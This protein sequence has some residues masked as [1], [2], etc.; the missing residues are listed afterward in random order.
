M[1]DEEKTKKTE[2]TEAQ[3]EHKDH[4]APKDEEPK[5]EAAE[6]ESSDNEDSGTAEDK[7]KS[8]LKHKSGNLAG[9]FKRNKKVSIPASV[10]LLL[11]V[12]LAVP[13]TRYMTLGLFLKQDFSVVVLDSKT[14]KPVSSAQVSLRGTT[15]STD[16]EGKATVRV[17]VGQSKLTIS[18]TYYKTAERG[19]TVT[20]SKPD[21]LILR[22]E[23]TGLLVPISVTNS[24]TRQAVANAVLTAGQSQAKTDDKGQATLVVP[25]GTEE[26]KATLSGDG[27]NTTDIIVK[28]T[29]EEDDTNKF[30][31]TPSGKIYFLSNQSGK[32]DVIKS[33][34]D[35]KNRE[36]VLPGTGKEKKGETVLLA[37]RDWKYLALKSR[38]DGGD[39]DKLFL[40]STADGKTTVMDEGEA[41]FR[42]TGWEDHKFIY[43]VTRE[44][45]KEWEAKKE[46][47]KSYDA[48]GRKLT[49]L[50]ET[51][52]S[53]K[54]YDYM[55]E[56]FNYIFVIEG[57]IVYTKAWTGDP[58]SIL[59]VKGKAATLNTI[60]PAGGDKKIINSFAPEG[61]DSY[62]ALSANLRNATELYL[63]F[64]D[65][66]K[67]RFYEY[68]GGTLRRL[69]DSTSWDEFYESDGITYLESPSGGKAF[70]SQR[71]DGKLGLFVG[72]VTGQNGKQIARLSTEFQTYGWYTEDYLLLSKDGSELFVMPVS[73]VQKED[74]LL[75][76][77][78][79]YRS[80]YSYYG[81][82]G[83]YGGL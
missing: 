28:A 50:D 17:P 10:V 34:L 7:P 48:D 76:V 57:T 68:E 21:E 65:G 60:S 53:G 30:G 47:L 13:F 59:R 35:G 81:Y 25:I 74:E 6:A 40:I 52:A 46:A 14:G 64:H 1:D 38:R 73:G 49:T 78:D 20:L 51:A 80:E 26:L 27:Y 37:T 39:Y 15:A 32:I 36:T 55:R 11:V 18:K 22:L 31:L 19:V 45:R 41:S 42:I 62:I 8:S 67:P 79:Y 63:T 56:T 43:T 3:E 58:S 54:Q 44:K 82:G 9:W 33:D 2:E 24:I 61:F 4:H 12:L 29:T 23:A 16:G 83:G 75:K 66:D 72:G 70:W 69:S 77:T 5:E 71:V